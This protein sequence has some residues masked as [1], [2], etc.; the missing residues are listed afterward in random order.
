MSFLY[1]YMGIAFQKDPEGQATKVALFS[2]DLY[3]II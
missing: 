2:I 3:S 1:S